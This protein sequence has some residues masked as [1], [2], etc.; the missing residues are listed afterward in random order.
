MLIPQGEQIYGVRGYRP[1]EPQLVCSDCV[2]LLAPVQDELIARVAPAHQPIIKPIFATKKA[3]PSFIVPFSATLEK[4]CRV[5]AEILGNFFHFDSTLPSDRAIPISMLEKA[6]GIAVMTVVRVGFLVTGTVGTG[7]VIARLPCGSWSAPSAIGTVGLGGGIEAG[8]ELIEVMIILGSTA[9]VKVFHAPQVNLGAGLDVTVGLY[10]RSAAAA[11]AMSTTG[12]N[13][14][15]S[16]SMSKGLFAGISLQGSVIA[17]RKSMNRKFY[18]RDHTPSDLLNG[19]IEQPAAA[20]PLYDALDVLTKGVE[21]H[22]AMHEEISDMMGA[23]RACPC[24]RHM[25]HKRQIWN[26]KCKACGHAH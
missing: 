1:A 23:C 25:A 21:E 8:G 24:V 2:L 17:T 14:N 16:Y 22:V 18:V 9:A 19:L 7:L 11:A 3:G 26:K 13:A 6:Q 10:G 5:A 20:K 15:Y 4:E 12:L